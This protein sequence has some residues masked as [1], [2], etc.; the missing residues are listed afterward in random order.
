MVKFHTGKYRGLNYYV[1]PSKAQR[2]SERSAVSKFA[3]EMRKNPTHG[4]FIMRTALLSR[5]QF[6]W[7]HEF[8]V[9]EM[10]ILDFFCPETRIAVEVDGG[11]HLKKEQAAK[12]AQRDAWLLAERGIVT[13]RIRNDDVLN[14]ER[15][16]AFLTSLYRFASERRKE[17]A[18]MKRIR[19]G[20][21][22]T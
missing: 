12:D 11:Y 15:L 14:P 3:K 1:Y 17:R 6:V 16:L 10:F 8:Q 21:R 19:E 18:E 22:E 2:R 4:E 13:F 20:N 9:A 7:K 5:P